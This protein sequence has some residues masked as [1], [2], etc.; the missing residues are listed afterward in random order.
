MC[1]TPNVQCCTQEY[2]DE[3]KRELGEDLMQ[4]LKDQL[5]TRGADLEDILGRLFD[6][7]LIQTYH[8]PS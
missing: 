8:L 6:C 3:I 2:L 1:Q 5:D 7:E 4:G